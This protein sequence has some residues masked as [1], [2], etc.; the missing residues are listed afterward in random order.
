MTITREMAAKCLE[1][2]YT[3]LLEFLSD[4]SYT[5]RFHA[6]WGALSGL[7]AALLARDGFTGPATASGRPKWKS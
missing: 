2:D 6:G 1:L 3:G 7:I 5:K 4:G